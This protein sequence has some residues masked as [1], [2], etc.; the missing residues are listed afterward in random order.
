[1][2][3]TSHSNEDIRLQTRKHNGLS[4]DALAGYEQVKHWLQNILLP[5]REG[6]KSHGLWL[7]GIGSHIRRWSSS[8]RN[9]T[10]ILLMT[11]TAVRYHG[12]EMNCM[13]PN[14]T[15]PQKMTSDRFWFVCN[16]RSQECGLTQRKMM[17]YM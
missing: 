14:T 13:F 1:M 6:F 3:I 15:A 4:C 5:M 8:S 9:L 2:D 11:P 7:A 17:F 16:L 10:Q 12:M